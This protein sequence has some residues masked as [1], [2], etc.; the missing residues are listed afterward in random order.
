MA[1]YDGWWWYTWQRWNKNLI[2]SYDKVVSATGKEVILNA[3]VADKDNRDYT[4][5]YGHVAANEQI[6]Y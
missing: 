6:K 5:F 4:A 3:L 1:D 2:Q